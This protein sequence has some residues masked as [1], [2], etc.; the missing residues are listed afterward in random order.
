VKKW[1]FSFWPT[2]TGPLPVVADFTEAFLRVT[3]FSEPPA[4]TVIQNVEITPELQH[5]RIDQ[6]KWDLAN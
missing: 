6:S 2:G 4:C 1:H 3:R 5:C